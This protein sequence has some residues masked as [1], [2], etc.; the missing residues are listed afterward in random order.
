MKKLTALKCVLL[1]SGALLPNLVRADTPSAGATGIETVVVT[2]ER[3]EEKLVNTP[4]TVTV[5]SADRLVNA[6][7]TD[8]SGL[9]QIAPGLT[10]ASSGA[11]QQPTI[12]G[13]GTEVAGPGLA[14]NVATY[15]D[16][17][18][19]PNGNLSNINFFD[20]DNVQVLEGPQGTLYGQN[21]TGGAIIVSTKGPEFSPS[22]LLKVSY[23]NYNDTTAS[24]F[25]TDGLTDT[26]A[27]S[28]SFNADHSDGYVTNIAGPN[29]SHNFTA[30][31]RAKILWQPTEA[32]SFLLTYE[33]ADINNP[34]VFA[35]GN[36]K[37][38]SEGVFVPGAIVA[39]E[40]HTESH[41]FLSMFHSTSDAV[42]LK[43]EYNFSWA[44]LTSYTAG[45]AEQNYAQY[46]VDGSSAS[47]SHVSFPAAER[48]ASQEFE[49]SSNDTDNPLKWTAGL[50]FYDDHSKEYLTVLTDPTTPFKVLDAGEETKSFAAYLDATYRILPQ[51]F[52]TGGVRYS[53]DTVVAKF[54]S[55]ADNFKTVTRASSTYHAV[56]PR[57]VLRYQ[58]A[59]DQNVYASYNEGY[60]VGAFN[61]GGL[62]T[63][64]VKPEKNKAF[65]VGYK[66]V[67]DAWSLQTAAFYGKYSNLQ[68]SS[69]LGPIVQLVN[70]A[71]ATVWGGELMA[72]DALSD[73]LLLNATLAYTNAKYDSFPGAPHY[74]WDPLTGIVITPDDASG[75]PLPN[76]PDFSLKLGATYTRHFHSGVLSAS[77]NLLF[78]TDEYFDPFKFPTQSPYAVLNLRISWTPPSNRWTASIYARNLTDTDY[79][80]AVVEQPSGIQPIY[81]N[82]R[83]FGAELEVHL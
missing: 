17:V 15:L 47:L 82:P 66:V 62:S 34:S 46:D 35:F 55:F 48:T 5:M 70:A 51:L 39:N 36:Y 31:G 19:R 40:P 13:V 10:I 37:G 21:A 23:G 63:L 60:K 27:A 9:Q 61:A 18:Y 72:S 64:P 71:K 1:A 53:V 3:R 57:V 6:G 25:A 38:Y 83:L 56:T 11:H 7:V 54:D 81:G 50:L 4:A 14:S 32:L 59:D 28:I 49:L 79:L 20:V 76:S 33:H 43:S 73:E 24:L 58:F 78:Q 74:V 65:E 42:I 29:D 77:G 80:S 75:N 45:Q 44:T 69:Y 52:V 41:N 16:G 8:F 12:R 26:L 30:E 67:K 22:A 68:E 2:A